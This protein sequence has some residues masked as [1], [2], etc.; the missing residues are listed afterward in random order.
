VRYRGGFFESDDDF[1]Q[2]LAD[3]AFGKILMVRPSYALN[4]GADADWLIERLTG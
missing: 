4:G 3:G 1:S 2:A